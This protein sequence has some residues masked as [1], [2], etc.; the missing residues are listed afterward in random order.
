MESGGMREGPGSIGS[1]TDREEFTYLPISL[2]YR[3]YN[4]DSEFV[5]Q[6]S[7]GGDMIEVTEKGTTKLV[8]E[9]RSYYGETGIIT[10]E[11][12]L[13][14]VLNTASA[15]D[16]VIVVID[17]SNPMIFEEFESEVEAIL[18]GFGGNRAA[19]VPDKAFLE[20]ISGQVEPSGLLPLQ[21]PANMETVEAQFEDVPRDMQC[22]VDG[23]DNTYDFAFGL[24]WSGVINDSRTTKYNVPPIVG[25]APTSN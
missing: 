4:A 6:E 12:H 7:L 2:Q 23:D 1:I 18:V 22:Y 20:L 21:M 24:N 19:N 17:M 5:R 11:D 8:K 14:L 3:P 9:N 15:I 13:D 16:K 25:E 10:N